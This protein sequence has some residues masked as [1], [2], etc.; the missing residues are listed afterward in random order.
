MDG[1]LEAGRPI[2]E[3]LSPAMIVAF[4][5]IATAAIVVFAYGFWRRIAKYLIG[6]PGGRSGQLGSRTVSVVQTMLAHSTLRKRDSLVG[7]AHAMMFYGFIAL[8][9]GTIIITLDQ[10]LLKPL[11]PEL[12]FWKGDFYKIFS[13]V[14]DVLG[15]GLVA[16]LVFM[17]VRRWI[18]RP[19]QLDYSR[20]DRSEDEYSRVG[21]RRDDQIFLWGLILLAATGFLIEAIRIAIAWH[22]F[23]VWSV[24]GWHLAKVLAASGLSSEIAAKLH[25]FGWWFHAVL[26]LTFI[27]YLPYSKAVHMLLGWAGLFLR[28]PL[29]GRRLPAIPDGADQMGYAG[30]SDFSRK[31]LLDLD[32]C[33]KCGRCH[34]SCPAVAGGWPLS[35]RDVILELRENAEVALGGGSLFHETATKAVSGPIADIGITSQTL[36][37]CTTC[38]ACV[39]ICPVGVEHIPLIV[40]M[41]R[42][43]VEKG[44]MDRNL[45]G[46]LEKLARYG[47][48]FGAPEQD[49]GNW[50]EGLGF[51]VK[52]ARKTAVDF[53]WFVGDFASYDPIIRQTTRRAA[54][55]FDAAG[56]DF[57]ILY[58]GE[59]NSGNDV[60]RVGEEGLF[61]FLAE[62]NSSV[63]SEA[64]FKTIVT[65]DPHS[66]N[67][68]KFEYPELGGSI[69]HYTE[70]ISDLIKD[71][72]LPIKK[73]LDGRVTYHDP[74]YLSR[75]ATLTEPPREILTALGF[76]L[77][78]MERNRANNFCCGAGGGRI[79]MSDS[80]SAERPSEQ[81][82]KEALEIDGIGHFAV[83]CP[84]C[85]S[86]Y[87][88]A[89]TATG[90]EA[91]LQ[92]K[93]II[94]F[95]E[96]AVL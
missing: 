6:R 43:L 85:F 4:Y 40:Q 12:R 36:W 44:D 11:S 67:T 61:Q 51:E 71:G 32:A 86:M 83:A 35:P 37:S 87:R 33:T 70:V 23:E 56:L 72:G 19:P 76:T 31:E 15:F 69:R 63:L 59:R 81:R 66:Y 52:D 2:F 95:V 50:T 78:E 47:N 46:T 42:H 74:C 55:I 88:E 17:A 21:Y 20:L 75:Y 26:A 92:V 62:H 60:R 58:D 65:A 45:Q 22:P 53:L 41:R 16:G 30:L 80:G 38:L 8:F 24:V 25:P 5:V 27:A 54:R 89:V 7:V 13:L 28:D 96:E 3:S 14:L 48:S 77:V 49:R 64:T 68:L 29:A 73:R 91:R 57:G 84:K 10:D 9:I 90:N 93:D 39:E 94:E 82:I 1:T 18:T 34:A 79:W